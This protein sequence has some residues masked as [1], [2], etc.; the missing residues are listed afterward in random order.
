MPASNTTMQAE[1]RLTLIFYVSGDRFAVRSFDFLLR[2]KLSLISLMF[3]S[4][5]SDEIVIK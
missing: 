4:K 5:I 3:F 2:R 1:N